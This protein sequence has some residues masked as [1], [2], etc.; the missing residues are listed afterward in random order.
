MKIYET[1]IERSRENK[2]KTLKKGKLREKTRH[3]SA[4][5]LPKAHGV[6]L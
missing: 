5:D 1:E 4:R 2:G 3:R 6:S